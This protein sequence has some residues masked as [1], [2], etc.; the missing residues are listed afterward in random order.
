MWVEIAFAA[1]GVVILW[2]WLKIKE[3]LQ[4]IHEAD[5]KI[6]ELQMPQAS[7]TMEARL[8]LSLIHI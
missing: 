8:N 7:D 3:Y 5:L 6:V 1:L 2:L 4:A